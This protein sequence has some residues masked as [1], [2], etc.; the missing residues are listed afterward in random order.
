MRNVTVHL[1][2]VGLAMIALLASAGGLFEF[3]PL[4][5]SVQA[6]TFGGTDECNGEERQKTCGS[7]VDESYGCGDGTATECGIA[8]TGSAC[9]DDNAVFAATEGSI[10]ACVYTGESGTLCEGNPD[11]DE[12]ECKTKDAC[13]CKSVSETDPETGVITVTHSCD[14]VTK[15]SSITEQAEDVV[16][17]GDCEDE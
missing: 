2:C 16:A 4:N 10:F 7:A 13:E 9:T 12:Q 14:I 3:T 6:A 5:D 17:H 1:G 8:N 11:A 15:E